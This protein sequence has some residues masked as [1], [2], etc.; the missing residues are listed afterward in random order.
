MVGKDPPVH[1]RALGLLLDIAN[2]RHALSRLI[3]PALL[4]LDTFLCAVIIWKVP[5]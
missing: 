1:L 4:V 2:G 5:C 3:P